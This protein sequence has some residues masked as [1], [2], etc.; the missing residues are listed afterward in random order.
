MLA[1]MV[2]HLPG[3][4]RR[5]V[6]CNDR[7]AHAFAET[8]VGDRERRGLEHRGMLDCQVLD[9]RRINIVATADDEVL[10]AA[11]DLQIAFGIEAPEVAGEKPA[12]RVERVLG[13]RLVVEITEHQQPAAR[14]DLAQFAGFRLDVGVFLVPQARLIAAARAPAGRG[15]HLDIVVR[16]R[17]LVRAVFRH[18]VNVLRLNAHVE[19]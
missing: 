14:A 8:L 18:A 5:A 7:Q 16:E 19:K 3:V 1:K 10:L 6:A 4:G 2:E 11:D 17:V 13:R 12:T 15:D 9:M